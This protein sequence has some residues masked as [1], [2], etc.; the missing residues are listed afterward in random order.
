TGEEPRLLAVDTGQ[1]QRARGCPPEVMQQEALAVRARQR[2]SRIARSAAGKGSDR[3]RRA[4]SISAGI[5]RL[6]ASWFGSAQLVTDG[7]HENARAASLAP[8]TCISA[9][10]LCP[11]VVPG[12]AQLRSHPELTVQEGQCF[13]A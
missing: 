8:D 9:S 10:S 2:R 13:G 12:M 5:Q 7:G 11:D 3:L 1:A 6:L 4:V